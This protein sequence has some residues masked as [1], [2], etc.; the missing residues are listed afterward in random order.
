MKRFPISVVVP[1]A[2]FCA[3][4]LFTKSAI[5]SEVYESEK[6]GIKATVPEGWKVINMDDEEE[7]GAFQPVFEMKRKQALDG[8]KPS[9]KL[10]ANKVKIDDIE[11]FGRDFVSNIQ[12]QGFRI[13]R[14]Q[15]STIGGKPAFEATGE[16]SAGPITISLTWIFMAGE[17]YLFMLTLS[18]VDSA[19]VGDEINQLLESIEY[20]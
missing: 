20:N 16:M 17:K 6:Y 4:G 12:K 10:T 2:L 13:I 9:A 3:L 11:S 19:A 8:K 7:E 5:S 15:V 14:Q 18:D 1:I